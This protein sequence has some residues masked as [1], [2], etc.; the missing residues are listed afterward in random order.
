[1]ISLFIIILTLFVDDHA[2]CVG[3]CIAMMCPA[4]YTVLI[5]L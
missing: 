3:A 2:V 5:K 1:M 4:K